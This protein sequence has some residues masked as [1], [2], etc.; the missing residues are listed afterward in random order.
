MQH[1]DTGYTMVGLALTLARE[2]HFAQAEDLYRQAVKA[3]SDFGESNVSDMWY[4]YAHGAMVAE[5]IPD[6]RERF[7]SAARRSTVLGPLG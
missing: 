3:S 1:P 2:G 5:L 6:Q 4:E 7:Q